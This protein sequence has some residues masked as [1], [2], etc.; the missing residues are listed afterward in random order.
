MSAKKDFV[1]TAEIFF[2]SKD[3]EAALEWFMQSEDLSSPKSNGNVEYKIAKCCEGLGDRSESIKWFVKSAN[4]GC[5]NSVGEV[6]NLAERGSY[7]GMYALGMLY[8]RG[9][10]V[11]SNTNGPVEAANWLLKAAKGGR[12]DAM[13]AIGVAYREGRGLA[14][15]EN[16]AM[17]WLKKAADKGNQQAQRE[18]KRILAESEETNHATL[19][20][21]NFPTIGQVKKQLQ[22]LESSKLRQEVMALTWK[23]TQE[24]EMALEKSLEVV[25]QRKEVLLKSKL[26]CKVC[27]ENETDTVFLECG[28]Q[29]CCGVCA[30]ELKQCPLCR[31]E[32]SRV[33]TIFTT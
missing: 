29:C 20:N 25:R 23:E 4:K 14:K 6:N 27:L 13:Y 18:V 8:Q 9:V 24:L 28:H 15:D 11:P 10:G 16:E 2:H 5:I 31:R 7:E 22:A 21:A 32:I 26:E 17:T 12:N 30:K 3:Y 33:V 19:R 1:S